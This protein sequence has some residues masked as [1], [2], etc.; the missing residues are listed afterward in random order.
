METVSQPFFEVPNSV[1]YTVNRSEEVIS[2][3]RNSEREFPDPGAF[4]E[5]ACSVQE[6]WDRATCSGESRCGAFIK[7]EMD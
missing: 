4:G 3:R 5:Q 2:H 1:D 6:P 7:A